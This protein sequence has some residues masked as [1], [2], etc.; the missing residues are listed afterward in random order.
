MKEKLKLGVVPYL[1][2][3][4][5]LRGLGADFPERNWIRATP[6]ELAPLLAEGRVD[7]AALSTFEAIRCGYAIVPGVMIGADGPVRSV[8]LYSRVPLAEIRTVL[9][10]R[11]SLSSTHLAQILAAELLRISPVYTTSEAPLRAEDI[12]LTESQDAVLVIGDTALRWEGKFPHALD[13]AAG[14]KE[15]TGLPFVFAAWLVRDGLSLTREQV[16]AFIRARE[17]GERDG[18]ILA[19]EAS[20]DPANAGIRDLHDYFTRA[21]RH[22]LGERE[23]EGLRLYRRKLIAHQFI[24]NAAPE[25][26]LV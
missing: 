14:W 12:A 9:L 26:K 23:L 13:L 21:I 24:D 2:V 8:M 15:L 3:L 6:R 17:C 4:P 20:A 5:L 22:R 16:A 25:I 18:A 1:N 19:R 10:D 7:V 11:A